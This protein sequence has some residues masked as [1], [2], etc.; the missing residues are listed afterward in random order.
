MTSAEQGMMTESEERGSRVTEHQSAAVGARRR[1][2][3][4]GLWR[5]VLPE[6]G[7]LLLILPIVVAGLA[8]LSSVFF[9]GLGM[10]A[11]VV[12]VLVVLAALF[13]ARGFGMLEIL[14]LRASGRPRIE[15]PRWDRQAP[16]QGAL[17]KTLAPLIDGHYWLYLLHGMIVAPIVGILSWTVVVSWLSVALF[18]T[19]YWMWQGLVGFDGRDGSLGAGLVDWLHLPGGETAIRTADSLLLLVIGLAALALL[20]FVTRG[21]TVMNWAIAQGMLG[22]FRS[23]RL[24]SEVAGLASSRTAAVSAEGSALRRLERDIHDGPQQRLVRLQM[25]LA[26]AD[27]QLERDPEK[28]RALIEEAMTQSREAL[29]ELRALSRGFAPPILLD[30]GLVA[31]L[32]AL[33]HRSAVPVRFDARVPEG[34]ELPVELERNAYFIAAEALTNAV[35]HSGAERVDLRLEVRRIPET[36]ASWLDVVVE[37]AGRGGAAAVDGHG[38][39][40]LAERAH[41]L[42]GSLELSSPEGGPTR[43]AAHLPITR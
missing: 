1:A 10:L 25:D 30:R 4:L 40:G 35:K 14:R 29:D 31:A 2:G 42:G 34:L 21:F 9:T 28:A 6:L 22:V 43:V 26:A 19:T 27:R 36:D 17:A 23:E 37:D 7:Y 24:A 20:P 33:A 18:G 11:I 16:G 12:G 41:G 15:A 8:V 5:T 38:L 3:Y 32:D 39:A 13:I